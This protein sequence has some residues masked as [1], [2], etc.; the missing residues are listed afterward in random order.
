V[1][2]ARPQGSG[3]SNT[4]NSQGSRKK[5]VQSSA[6]HIYKENQA[7]AL[8]NQGRLQQA[9]EIYRELV[10]DGSNN[11]I[12]Y[13][14][15]GALLQMRGD[16][17]NAAACFRNAIK[18]NPSYPNT[19]NNLGVLLKEQGDLNAAITSFRT[20]LQI[21]PNHPDAH[22]NLGNALLQL[23]NLDAATACF[24]KALQIKPNHPD[25]HNNLG[26]ALLE[27]GNLNAAIACF[28]KALQIK[29][30]HPDAHNNLGNALLQLG[31]LDAATASFKE[32]LQL[33]PRHMKARFNKSLVMLL[34][35]D[36]KNGWEEYESRIHINQI[37]SKI[38]SLPT[39]NLWKGETIKPGYTLLLISEQGLGDTLQFMRY[40]FALRDQGI[41][42]SISAPQRLHPLIQSSGI[43]P[44]PQKHDLSNLG[45]TELWTPLLSVPRHLKVSPA[46]PVI[47][48]PYIKTP[49]RL[50]S[51]WRDLISTKTTP[52]IGMN[53]RGNREEPK[54]LCRNIPFKD[55][56]KLINELPGSFISLQRGAK[57]SEI[58]E[59]TRNFKATQHQSNISKAADSD[60]P[61]DL[62]EYAAIIA[63]CDLVITTGTT[64]AHIAGGIGIP[65]WVLLPRTPDWRWGLN[66]NETFWYPSVR[67]FRQSVQG[68]WEDVIDRVGR[69]L[70]KKFGSR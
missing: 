3:F 35:G 20:A 45:R 66:S 15:L 17:Q 43:D 44:S 65:T 1:S 64:V 54:T 36:Y 52:I 24:E 51:K 10:D 27:Q 23:G 53:W 31:N 42:V 69:E 8:I 62:L 14:N 56:K 6:H 7:I 30:N 63:N 41:K 68:E 38:R 28:K 55:F 19:H 46:N 50:N 5:H 26:N 60:K 29:P 34:Q 13:G 11:H 40:A 33:N 9:E 39:P 32:A 25:V 37:N 18:L 61:E 16:P 12:V 47:S 48:K 57:Q 49:E 21:N 67:L 22:N 2:Q 4:P 58:E 59:I 70:R